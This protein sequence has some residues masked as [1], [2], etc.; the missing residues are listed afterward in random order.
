MKNKET[1]LS[2]EA[3]AL[4]TNLDNELSAHQA[5][6]REDREL[7][8]LARREAQREAQLAYGA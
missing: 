1:E 4:L 8:R 6:T 5:L 2:L 3:L 7:A